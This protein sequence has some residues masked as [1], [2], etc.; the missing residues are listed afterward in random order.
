[1]DLS[2]SRYE[3][4]QLLR[5]EVRER[6]P[7]LVPVSEHVVQCI[8]FD[9]ISLR[10]EMETTSGRRL[11]VLSPGWWNQNEGP[12]FRGAQI[13]I[14]GEVVTGDVEVHLTHGAW[15]QHGHHLDPRYDNVL[16]AVVLE[17]TPPLQ[18]PRTSEGRQI[19]VLLL[20][21]AMKE[22]VDSI[23]QRLALDD[24]PYRADGA[25]G[26]CSSFMQT[27]GTQFA[28]NLIGLAG[29]WRAVGKARLLAERMASVGPDQAVY[30][31]F[32]TACGYSQFKTQ[33]R[34]IAQQ[35]HYERVRQL[36][37][38]D[39]QILEAALL[40]LAGLLPER[41]PPDTPSAPHWE[42]LRALREE[43][44][45]GL[46]VLPLA[47]S[48]LGV[49]PNN[50]PE[51]RLAGASLFLARTA[52]TGLVESLD[53][54][55]REDLAPAKRGRAFEMM[56]PK[57]VGF[58]SD[59]CMW[60]G[61]SMGKPCAML[62]AQRV[63]SI[64]GNV[65]VPAGLALARTRRDRPQEERVL[66]FYAAL[67]GEASNKVLKAMLPR[68]LGDTSGLKTTFRL[69]QGLLQIYQDWCAAN[70]SCHG[71]AVLRFLGAPT[72]MK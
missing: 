33:F 21:K 60:H 3:R 18:P 43:K 70:P 68:V 69:Q 47:W 17:T 22:D 46:R 64:I 62:G 11:R 7:D 31:A 24:Y 29:E 42:R 41:L 63:R 55:W 30:E 16:L 54:I 34:M 48:R 51:R 9:Q 27:R 38:Q 65:F 58:W 53:A 66:A 56:F 23:A 6:P 5:A 50:Y 71:C 15:T 72:K 36:A 20:P 1:M 44:L 67:P 32:L 49:R 35:F 39:P 40:H 4:Y 8:W 57:P 25:A 26:L 19:P 59:H 61:K 13:E 45:P 28:D 10:E 2:V 52:P 37:Q 12:D 14:D